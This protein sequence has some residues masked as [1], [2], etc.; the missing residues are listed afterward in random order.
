MIPT[1]AAGDARLEKLHAFET[2]HRLFEQGCDGWSVWR[3]LR[4][5]VH[6]EI[7]TEDQPDAAAAALKS[8]YRGMPRMM[9][10]LARQLI[11][12]PQA[13]LVLMSLASA[14][15]DKAGDRWR[16][17]YFDDLLDT[18]L[19]AF[20][21]ENPNSN[22]LN[23]RGADA[24]RPA[25]VNLLAIDLLARL[26][27]R[28]RPLPKDVQAFAEALSE[29]LRD[30][31]GVALPARWVKRTIGTTREQARIHERILKR[32]RPR[33]VLVADTAEFPMLIACRRVGVPLIEV[34]HG[35]FT[36]EHPDALPSLPGL[37]QASLL[38]PDRLAAFGNY[39]KRELAGT[40]M[41]AERIIPVGNTLIDRMRA[42]RA[43]REPS[44][45]L[46]IL[47][48]TQGI[49]TS[50]LVAWL[51]AFAAAAPP[52]MR[53]KLHIKLHPAYEPSTEPYAAL[54]THPQIEIVPGDQSPLTVDLLANADLHL[55]ISSTSHFDAISIGVPTVIIPLP[56][57]EIIRF[58]ADDRS[59]F[60]ARDPKH[61]WHIVRS[62]PSV[63][64]E[65][66]DFC[67]PNYVANLRALIDSL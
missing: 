43:K 65:G 10:Q 4:R 62:V 22:S 34:Q 11:A 32:V 45:E 33:A 1:D 47:A 53:W 14:L 37:D 15:R 42:L 13:D 66:H 8:R 64:D 24:A 29:R 16:D 41:P 6:R 55:S 31:L 23:A 49:A 7:T 39:W 25:Q 67:A 19:T 52:E 48:T 26:R 2:R 20:K 51:D 61:I 28:L 17:I 12:A 9:I 18:G 30:E 46:R 59:A 63:P 5:V 44:D 27:A 58:I 3:V 54:S 60:V 35:T 21:I 50:H 38:L 56:S 57:H 36:T 40:A